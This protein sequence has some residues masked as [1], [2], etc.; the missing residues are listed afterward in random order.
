MKKVIKDRKKL[1]YVTLVRWIK[2][3]Y[4]KIKNISIFHK[5]YRGLTKT[6]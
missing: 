5:L 2:G 1:E 4:K 3:I 6:S